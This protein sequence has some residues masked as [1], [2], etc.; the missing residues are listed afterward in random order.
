MGDYYIGACFE[1]V[2]IRF[3]RSNLRSNKNK[4]NS[5][6]F[7]V[8]VKLKMIDSIFDFL[9]AKKRVE[10]ERTTPSETWPKQREQEMSQS[11]KMP[12]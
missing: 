8:S 5:R 7:V 1:F 11:E 6:N 4:R 10:E 2:S 9:S 12:V 3:D